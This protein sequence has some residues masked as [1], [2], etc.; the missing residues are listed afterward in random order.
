MSAGA[1]GVLRALPL[2]ALAVWAWAAA[3]HGGRVRRRRRLGADPR[4]DGLL[5]LLRHRVGVLLPCVRPPR[6][7][8]PELLLVPAGLLICW[9]LRSPVPVLAAA[10]AV[11][12][13]R[14]WRLARRARGEQQQRETAVAELCTALA[15]ELRTGAVP[16]RALEAVLAPGGPAADTLHRS[17][18][19]TTA[20]LAAARFAGDVPGALR[21]TAALPGAS[22]TAALAACWQVAADSGAG[23]AAGL[24]RVAEALRADR[25]LREAVRGEL[26][27]PRTTAV[28]L[29]LLP[30]PGLLMGAALGADPFQVLLHT[31]SGLGCLAAGVALE[32]AGLVWTA[33]I[34]RGAERLRPC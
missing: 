4:S 16:V 20:L 23:L 22:G 25:A 34:V 26:A 21:H 17:G 10:L 18:I 27:G 19:D 6:W 2:M 15:A 33:R 28:V 8:V 7:A 11:R 5:P 9:P 3:Q 31:P 13:L 14:R 29:A 12:P 1:G 24:D 32:A 30:A